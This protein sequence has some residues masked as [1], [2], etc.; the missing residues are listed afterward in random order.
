MGTPAKVTVTDSEGQEHEVFICCADCE[1][2][3]KADPDTYLAKLN[4]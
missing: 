3:I 4:Q 2:S 1:E